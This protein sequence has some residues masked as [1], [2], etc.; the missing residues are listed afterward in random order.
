[1]NYHGTTIER[2]NIAIKTQTIKRS[3]STPKRDHWLGDGIYLYTEK[4]Y[5]FR[6]IKMMYDDD[7]KKGKYN[8]TGHL[9]ENFMVLG[10]EFEC[11]YEREFRLTSNPVHGMV[12]EKVRENEIKRRK[13][14]DKYKGKKVSDGEILNIMFNEL[15]YGET[16][17][18]VRCSFPTK[19]KDEGSRITLSQEEQICVKNE[20]II[21][22]IFDISA[23]VDESMYE[24]VYKT[25]QDYKKRNGE[26]YGK[27]NKSQWKKF[28]RG[29]KKN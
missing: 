4:F 1:M 10:V 17:D 15:K 2:G 11:D 26:C 20:R 6:W 18:L 29:T 21:K 13:S 19:D 16:Y 22:R 24:D 27:R 12:F 9:F 23:E 14:I 25:F 3:V 28:G 8:V 5:A 7:I